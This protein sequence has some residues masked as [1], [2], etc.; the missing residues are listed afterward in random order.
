MMNIWNFI[1]GKLN[2]KKPIYLMVVIESNGS[3]PGKQGF[4]M[5]VCGDG[6]L[7]GSIGGGSMEFNLVEN[8]KKMLS[9]KESLIFIKKQVHKGNASEGSGMVCSGEQT[10]AFIPLTPSDIQNL[11]SIT[12]C[13]SNKENGILEISESGYNF[14]LSDKNPEIQYH[15]SI[16]NKEKWKFSEVIG[17]RSTIYI[18]GAGHVGFAVSKLFSQIGFKVILIDNRPDLEMLTDN[19]FADVKL[20]IDYKKIGDYILEGNSSYVIIMTNNHTH[21]KDV[22]SLLLRKKVKYLG[23][24]GSKEKVASIKKQLRIGGFTNN[25]FSHLHAPIGISIK[26]ETPDEI[27]VSIAAEIIRVKNTN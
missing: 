4:S 6:D 27:A 15:C 9:N 20:V 19:L 12:S 10:V 21:D 14:S 8:C 25:E 13:L 18:I 16:T 5:A 24:M 22:L 3:S 2:E 11:V 7:H 17:Y 1:E 26:S 23:M